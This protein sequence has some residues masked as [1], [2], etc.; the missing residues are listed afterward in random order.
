[1]STFLLGIYSLV[2]ILQIVLLIKSVRHKTKKLWAVLLLS[3]LVSLAVA[4]CLKEYYNSLPGYGFMPGFTYM[5]EVL[6]SFGASVLYGAVFL[7]SACIFI[8]IEEKRK[9]IMPVFA[10]TAFLLWIFGSYYLG[11]EIIRN[12]D[13]T[14]STGT[15]IGFADVH[16]GGGIEQWP[17]I[18]FTVEGNRYQQEFPMFEG[19]SAGKEITIYYYPKGDTYKLVLAKTDHKM[20]YIPAFLFG[21]IAWFIRQRKKQ[22]QLQNSREV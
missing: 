1:M 9:Q 10:L 7:I 4:T 5:G 17:V 13:K 18:E 16:T 3:E 6:C 15:I 2:F 12:F 14:K 8:V 22:F 21:C 20:F 19:A 11:D